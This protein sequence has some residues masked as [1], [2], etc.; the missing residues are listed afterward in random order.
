[1]DEDVVLSELIAAVRVLRPDI[2][3]DLITSRTPLLAG[4]DTDAGHTGL[5][6]LELLEMIIYVEEE[7]DLLLP[8]HASL[9]EIVTFGDLAR[10]LEPMTNAG[11][12][13]GER[14]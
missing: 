7:R 10:S 5:D 1:M 6:S 3:A 2:S 9:D 4:D 14:R 12:S 11:W 13:Q 8:E